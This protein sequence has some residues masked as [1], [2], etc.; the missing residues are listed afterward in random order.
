MNIKTFF[1]LCAFCLCSAL[2]WGE[3]WKLTETMTAELE[4]HDAVRWELH[5]KTTKGSEAMPNYSRDNPAPWT[6]VRDKIDEIFVYDGITSIGSFAFSRCSNL[7]LIKIAKSVK[8]IGNDAFQGCTKL[9]MVY[10]YWKK[11]LSISSDI[12]ASVDLSKASLFA[13]NGYDKRYKSTNVWKDF[14]AI[15]SSTPYQRYF[16]VKYMEIYMYIDTAYHLKWSP[17]IDHFSWYIRGTIGEKPMA[18][19]ILFLSVILFF[20]RIAKKKDEPRQGITYVISNILFLTTCTLEIMYTI[21]VDNGLWFCLPEEVGWLW[22][23]INFFLFA[24]I[25]INQVLYLFDI[26]AD[27]LAN[28]NT[29]C[30]FRLGLYSWVGAFICGIFCRFFYQAGLPWVYTILCIMQLVQLVLIFKSYGKNIIGAFWCVFVYLFGTIGTAV[31]L[32]IF[33]GLL[34]LVVVLIAVGWMILKL[35]GVADSNSSRGKA[36]VDWSDGK[37]EEAEE[38]GRGILGERYY[39]GKDTG[40]EFQD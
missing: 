6:S 1:L 2:S 11:P 35:T 29:R 27:V 26:L 25:V 21:A 19:L 3:T 16:G 8:S 37:S 22:T 7:Y 18:L 5:I 28:G 23:V 17:T 4:L 40:R 14:G 30:D 38:T 33:I 32:L 31:T 10:V 24:G 13:E 39:K 36:R 9:S 15:Y 12:F 34:I 20:M